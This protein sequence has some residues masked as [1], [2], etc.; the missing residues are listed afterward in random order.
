M[1]NGNWKMETGKWK[2]GNEIRRLMPAAPLPCHSERSEE[3]PQ[4]LGFQ[5]RGFFAS[6]RMTREL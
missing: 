6:L 2:I 1:E 5:L 3:S 4:F